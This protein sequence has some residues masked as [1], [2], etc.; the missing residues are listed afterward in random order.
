MMANVWPYIVAAC[1]L[2]LNLSASTDTSI[3]TVSSCGVKLQQ[4]LS[5]LERRAK[6]LDIH[7]HF[8]D[9]SFIA[10]NFFFP[11]WGVINNMLYNCYMN[12]VSVM[13]QEF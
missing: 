9:F 5:G 6:T 13:D 2:S 11:T 8:S 4:V 1:R 7:I 10:I 12:I 3:T